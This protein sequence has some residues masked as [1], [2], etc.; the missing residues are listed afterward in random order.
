MWWEKNN[1]HSSC[2][3]DSDFCFFFLHASSR[4]EAEGTGRDK[5]QKVSHPNA[6]VATRKLNVFP[7][8]LEDYLGFK[9]S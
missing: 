2:F 8:F 3:C 6:T 9:S 4:D 1:T 5:E 7:S